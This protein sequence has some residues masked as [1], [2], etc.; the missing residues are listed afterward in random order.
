M[1]TSSE[2][3]TL[4]PEES[5]ISM[6]NG[7]RNTEFELPFVPNY[8][9]NPP[10]PYYDMT[11]SSPQY[12]TPMKNSVSLVPILTEDFQAVSLAASEETSNGCN[13]SDQKM[14][15][16]VSSCSASSS[17]SSSLPLLVKA[18]LAESGESDFVE[19]EVEPMSFQTLLRACCEELEVPMVEVSKIRKLPNVIVRKD[20]DV[21][22]MKTGQEL[23]IVLKPLP[24]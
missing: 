7:G 4:F 9:K 22:R 24:F 18:R 1:T 11:E 20:Q 14:P 16:T 19:V 17:P 6:G 21:Q 8:L 15:A 3:L 5:R 2:V 10:F 12:T 13:T 23:E